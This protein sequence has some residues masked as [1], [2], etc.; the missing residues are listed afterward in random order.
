MTLSPLLEI[1]SFHSLTTNNNNNYNDNNK[2]IIPEFFEMSIQAIYLRSPESEWIAYF[3]YKVM[4]N[5]SLIIYCYYM[6]QNLRFF[7]FWTK[8]W[9]IQISGQW[10]IHH[11]LNRDPDYVITWVIM[12]VM[13]Y[14]W[15]GIKNVTLNKILNNL[16]SS[17][18]LLN[19]LAEFI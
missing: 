2:P 7:F 13:K 10:N 8:V 18:C 12:V 6:S 5:Y 9:I 1:N 11:F 14:V 17:Q 3:R 4:E 15:I 19:A 16:S